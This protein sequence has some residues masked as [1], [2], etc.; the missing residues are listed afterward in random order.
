M[1]LS[2]L[3][4]AVPDPLDV[5]CFE[6]GLWVMAATRKDDGGVGVGRGVWC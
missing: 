3:I 5:G 2:S 4:T 6:L 1:G